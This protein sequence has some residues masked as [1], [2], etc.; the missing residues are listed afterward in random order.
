M[1]GVCV[2]VFRCWGMIYDA[3]EVSPAER[4]PGMVAPQACSTLPLPLC[5]HAHMHMCH[6]TVQKWPA[7]HRL[8][9][10]ICS[11]PASGRR[12]KCPALSGWPGSPQQGC[13]SWGSSPSAAPSPALSG[14]QA[15]LQAPHFRVGG[16]SPDA[17][18]PWTRCLNW[19]IWQPELHHS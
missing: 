8:K 7:G 5:A 2:C 13:S 11:W 18:C 14:V 12:T 10:S 3:H 19:R 16:T 9:R 1:E 15:Q 6:I 4:F 17:P